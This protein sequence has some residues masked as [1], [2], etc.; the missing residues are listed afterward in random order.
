MFLP[1]KH[2]ERVYAVD[3]HGNRRSLGVIDS[4]TEEVFFRR[5]TN[6]LTPKQKKLLENKSELTIYSEKLGGFIHM[7]YVKNEL[8]FNELNIDNANIS[9]LIY[10]ATYIDY[11]NNKENL[12]V[13]YG[14]SKKTI[15]MTRKDIKEKMGLKDRAFINFMKEMKEKSLIYEVDN[16]FYINPDYFNRGK[17]KIDSKSYTRVFID[18]TRKLYENCS[19]RQH[20]QLSY[21][22]QLVPY[23]HKELN[24]ICGNPEAMDYSKI[25]KLSLK[26]ICEKLG[27]STNYE[28]M[29]KLRRDLL[30]FHIDNGEEKYFLLSY[31]KV[32]NGYGI[33]DYFT[34]NPYVIWSGMDTCEIREVI[35]LF[36]FEQ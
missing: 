29:K 35:D 9:R 12:L 25:N 23:I 7:Y 20:K 4:K 36:F 19:P 31:V 15:P 18:T 22:F 21:I 5:K 14:Q 34:V 2:Y 30:K 28:T 16:K 13:R 26:D 8:L 32:E 3:T 17:N 27:L 33:K 6:E 24:I 10:L 1:K 11:N